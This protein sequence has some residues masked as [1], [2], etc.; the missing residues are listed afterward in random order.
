MDTNECKVLM[1]QMSHESMTQWVRSEKI[2]V[3]V[4]TIKLSIT[5]AQGLFLTWN[6]DLGCLLAV[7]RRAYGKAGIRNPEPEPEKEPELKLRPG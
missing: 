1:S 7:P 5:F 2:K 6:L 3:S 4:E